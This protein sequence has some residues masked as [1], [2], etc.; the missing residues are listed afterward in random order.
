MG[1]KVSI[2]ALAKRNIYIANIYIY[3]KYINKYIFI[4]KIY[5]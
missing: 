3:G 4:L 5:I 1:L 2:K